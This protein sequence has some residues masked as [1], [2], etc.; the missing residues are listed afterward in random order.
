MKRLLVLYLGLLILTFSL[1]EEPAHA[2]P[3]AYSN[4]VILIIRH[5]EKPDDGT[6][7]L[8]P[9]GQRH[10]AAYVKYFQTYM[11]DSRP[12]HLDAIYAAADSANDSRPRLTV[13]P[14]AKALGLTVDTTYKN[15]H[16]QDLATALQTKAA[17]KQV[18]ICW[19]HHRIPDLITAL[20]A[21]ANQLVPGGIWPDDQYY[22]V[23]QLCYDKDGHLIQ[24]K[25][26]RIAENL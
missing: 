11:I 14:L 3:P 4:A 22:W 19:H 21:D 13:E 18:L 8:T 25:T 10:A 23:I 9:A 20:G 1:M 24:S 2:V 17:G 12:L 15:K 16:L 6:D 26:L 7:G 5:A